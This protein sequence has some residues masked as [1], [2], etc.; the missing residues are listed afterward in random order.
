MNNESPISAQ[1]TT[2]NEHRV[3]FLFSDSNSDRGSTWCTAVD[4]KNALS[5]PTAGPPDR[6]DLSKKNEVGKDESNVR[7][8]N[9]G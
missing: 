5:L 3:L 9:Q 1:K 4:G 2:T 7:E 6:N 8:Y